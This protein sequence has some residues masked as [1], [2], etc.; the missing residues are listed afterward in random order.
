VE[1]AHPTVDYATP[2]DVP[3]SFELAGVGT[4]ILAA[5]LDQ[6]IIITIEFGL[7]L[8]AL[9]LGMV[10]E[11]VTEQQVQSFTE[12]MQQGG[13]TALFLALSL[14]AG[15]V[16]N[17]AYYV[18]LEMTTNG[19]TVGKRLLRIRVI[20][21]GGYPITLTASLLR[22]LARLVDMIPNTYVVGLI[23]MIVHRQEKRMGDMLAGTV[24]VRER[25]RDASGL[26]FGDER[27]ST[28]TERQYHL[29]RAALEDLTEEHEQVLVRFFTRPRLQPP[30]EQ[31]IVAEL[32]DGFAA[33][34]PEPP[35]F[36]GHRDRLLFLKELYL[37]LR[38]RRELG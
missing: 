19:Q 9:A 10:A 4:R 36:E 25:T 34:L 33:R 31:R 24:V 6:L 1:S 35:L 17:F 8:F 26:P 14:L 12:Q 18:L 38:E 20:R 7:V 23:T 27:Y 15:F 13:P 3:L 2:E 22:N 32:A 11:L 37:A 5:L 29:D 28:L 21:D 16:V 30:Q